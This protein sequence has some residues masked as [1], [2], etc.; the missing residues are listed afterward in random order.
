MFGESHT[1]PGADMEQIK[2]SLTIPYLIM[3]CYF[4]TNWFV[5]SLH[6]PTSAPE[7]KFLSFVMFL[8]T[9]ILW[10]LMILISCLEMLKNQKIEMSKLIPIILTIFTFSISYYLTYIY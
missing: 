8:V 5:F 3:T 10:P 2:L 6:H 1:T 9:T 4:L 7:D